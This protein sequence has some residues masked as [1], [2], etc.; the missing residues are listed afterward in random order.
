LGEIRQRGGKRVIA[1][2]GK[3]EFDI[4]KLASNTFEIEWSPRSGRRQAFPEV[5]R[6]QSGLISRLRR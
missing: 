2:Y 4:A 5:D 6:E 1:F 3:S